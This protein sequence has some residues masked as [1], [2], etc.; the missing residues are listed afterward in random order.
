[1]DVIGVRKESSNMATHQELEGSLDW[2]DEILSVVDIDVELSFEGV[3]D[4]DAGLDAYLVIL[5][6]PVSLVCDWNTIPSVW[7]K[8]S[9]SLTTDS[10]DSLGKNVWL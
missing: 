4:Q 2:D 1:M 7:V 3:V 5:W 8:V 10:D 9:K 6:V